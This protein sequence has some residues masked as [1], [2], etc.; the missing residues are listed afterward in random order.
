MPAP[1]TVI[2]PLLLAAVLIAS[3]VAK[4]RRPD[5]LAGWADLGVP[6]VF[7]RTWLL[8]L[9]PWGE[10]ALGLAL[11]LLGGL[12]GE[13]AALTAVALMVGYLVFVARIVRSGTDA[14]CA[15]F[16]ARKRVTGATVTRNAW[17]VALAVTVAATTWANP[18]WGGPLMALRGDGWLW[19][20]GLLAAAITVAITMWPA[21]EEPATTDAVITE[22]AGAPASDDD[23]DYIRSL[24]PAV[25]VT[26]AGGELTDLRTLSMTGR[27][28]LALQLNPGCGSCVDVYDRVDKIRTMLPEVSVRLLL[29]QEP[30]DSAW[31]E[32]SEPESLHDPNRYVGP[33]IGTS[34]T[35]SAVLFGL[36]GLLAGGPV[37]G[38]QQIAEFV[39]D[40][41]ESL[42]GERPAQPLAAEATQS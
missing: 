14:S 24:T 18:L 19:V 33:S 36:D 26:L 38:Y 2:P 7:R 3:G 8:R 25:P 15:C 39:D 1:L 29:T 35:P 11:A 22:A 6:A 16:G 21:P 41:Y 4:L 20:L 31:T 40:I 23:L 12:L 37:T 13:L 17:Y 10:I 42:H 5:D 9:H 30:G 32:T 34:R 27:P 28:L